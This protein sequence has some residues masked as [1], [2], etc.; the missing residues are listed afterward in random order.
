M[1]TVEFTHTNNGG[2]YWL[3]DS[4][5]DALENAG[6]TVVNRKLGNGYG[7][8]RATI[9]AES[10]AAATALWAETLPHFDPNDEGC[11]C[12][13]SPFRFEVLEDETEELEDEEVYDFN[14]YGDYGSYNDY[15]E[16]YDR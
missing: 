9:V 15:Y 5:W 11:T 16:P 12:C 14:M 6:W 4:D 8:P 1:V 7:F 3:K 2:Y 13:S 10:V